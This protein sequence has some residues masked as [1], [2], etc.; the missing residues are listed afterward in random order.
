M[1]RHSSLKKTVTTY[2]LCAAC[3]PILILGIAFLQLFSRSLEKEIFERNLLTARTA[4]G[5]I[6]RYLSDY[7]SLLEYTGEQIGLMEEY[8]GPGPHEHLEL[9]VRRYKM[10]TNVRLLDALGVIKT[11]APYRKD[12][13]GLDHSGLSFIKKAG[14]SGRPSW[15]AVYLSSRSGYPAISIA[16][17]YAKGILAADLNLEEL[18]KITGVIK[19]A[20]SGYAA[21]IDRT[22][23][24]I[25]HPDASFVRE[26]VNFLNLEMI[27]EGLK[28]KEG[29]YP[30]VF[31]KEKNIGSVA[32]VPETG[33]LTVVIQPEREA[34]AAVINVRRILIGLTVLVCAAALIL[35][36]FFI[37]RAVAPLS[38]LADTTRKVS[39]GNYS[40]TTSP[41]RYEEI[42]QISEGLNAMAEAIEQRETR[43]KESEAKYRDLF[44]NAV[45]IIYTLDAE[46][47]FLVVNEAVITQMGY[48]REEVIGNSIAGFIHNDDIEKAKEAHEKVIN[49]ESCSFEMRGKRKDGIY[50]WYSVINRPIAGQDGNIETMHCIARDITERRT[51]EDELKASEKRF[52]DLFD[53]V[54]DLVYTQDLEGRLTS[55]NRAMT[56]LFGYEPGEFIGRPVSDFM[57]PELRPFFITEYVGKIKETGRSQGTSV[58]FTKDGRKLYVEYLSNLVKPEKGLPYIS[59]IGRD[60][61]ARV[62]ADRQIRE[63]EERISAILEA[64]PNPIAVYDTEGKLLFLNRSFTGVFGWSADELAG[65]KIPFVPEDEVEK[66]MARIKELYENS[67]AGPLETRRLTKDGRVLGVLISAS[68]IKGSGGKPRGMVVSLTDL[69]ERKRIEAG[70]QQ[71]QKME[72]IGTLAGGIA[73]D[74]NNLLMAIQ[75]NISLILMDIQKDSPFYHGLA[76]IEKYVRQGAQLTRQLLGFARGGKYEVRPTDIG[77]LIKEHNVIFGRAR[78]DIV[79]REDFQSDLWPVAADKGQLEQVLMN[80]YVNAAQAMTD[81]EKGET[82]VGGAIFV[83]TE[84]VSLGKVQAESLSALPGRYV[85]FSVT[86]K[87]SGMDKATRQRIFEPFF[88]TKEKGR[89]TGLGLASVYG[90]VKNH[91]GFIAVESAPGKGS[92]FHIYL[93][94]MEK[95]VPRETQ[96]AGVSQ[97]SI[98]GTGRLL[99]VDD[100]DMI[101]DVGRTMLERLGYEVLT[102]SGAMEAI[103]IFNRES[104]KIDLV[105]LDMIMPEMGGAAL[106]ERLKKINPAVRVLLSSGYS[107]EEQARRMLD[108]GRCG[109]IHKPFDLTEL[110]RKVAE[111]LG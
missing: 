68:L 24:A 96:R 11:V 2:G 14:S 43:L 93:P 30:Y 27:R 18:Q 15:S 37:K 1:P 97:G 79:I 22:G 95:E 60:V 31:G 101:L 107:L 111:V 100:E 6:S 48:N 57:K 45:D 109:F 35:V 62:M 34:F 104:A 20:G 69:T 10:L 50:R 12:L 8:L 99:L 51:A 78:K 5:E 41:A 23:T 87:G 44:E 17:P 9:L 74:F 90:I 91:G 80:L 83:K 21:I 106:F 92:S 71:I 61:T 67:Q 70:L 33:W 16:A 46:G 58:Y 19:V 13:I 28:G 72:A 98:K 25:A 42:R 47:R 36:G 53:S 29:T 86:D 75:G 52:R 63:R 38:I 4:A 56:T 105:I 88:T 77:S 85:R 66:T 64:T 7:M 82:A 73:H 110:G 76:D 84:N 40:L 55:A 108:G 54:S 59:G 103:E 3:I 102:A 89:G 26:R 94:A 49:G 65:K 81:Y 32:L 39:L